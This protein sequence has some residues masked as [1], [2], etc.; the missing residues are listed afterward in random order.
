[1][2]V[3]VNKCRITYVHLLQSAGDLQNDEHTAG[4]ILQM[5]QN[6]GKLMNALNSERRG[7]FQRLLGMG[8]ICVLC[9]FELTNGIVEK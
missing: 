4:I 2:Y 8:A 6:S 9:R 1:M 7:N 5:V 3:I